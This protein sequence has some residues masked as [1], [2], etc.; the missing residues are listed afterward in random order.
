M[1]LELLK[2]ADMALT[3]ITTSGG[4]LNTEQSD[5]FIDEIIDS[6]TI[7]KV[8]RTTPMN[9]PTMELSA[10][11]FGSRVTRPGAEATAVSSGD[12]AVP[13]IRTISLSSKLYKAQTNMTYEVLEDNI[14]KGTLEQAILR[15]F[16]KAVSR[17]IEE[18]VIRG[19]TASGDAYLATMNGLC[20]RVVSNVVNAASTGNTAQSY[21]NALLALADRYKSDLSSLRLFVTPTMEQNYRMA[22]ANRQTQLGDAF[23]TGHN[24]ISVMGVPMMKA[25]YMPT[26]TGVLIDP[27]N[28]IV[29]IQ[30]QIRI[31]SDKD[32]EAGIVK[33]VVTFRMDMNLE[34]EA[35][36]VKI[37]NVA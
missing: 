37:T 9:G 21:S 28:I 6:Q 14:A 33:Y 2:K 17:D 26:G 25:N 36:A 35:A 1:S 20:K 3:N 13:D 23:L 5:N 34:N 7:M 8:V 18:V 19:D 30:R 32:I 27:F 31:E 22:V 12:R 10:L 29:G 4:L 11:G 24:A 15:Q 16:I